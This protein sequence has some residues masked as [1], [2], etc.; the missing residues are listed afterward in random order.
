MRRDISFTD[1]ELTELDEILCREL[2]CTREELRRT[3]N[4]DFRDRVAHHLRVVQAIHH[5]T[6]ELVAPAAQ[7]S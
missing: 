6:V 1:E 4:R 2:N 5:K 7:E 3:R